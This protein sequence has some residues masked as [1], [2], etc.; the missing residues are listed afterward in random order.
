MLA[1][2]SRAA[3]KTTANDPKVKGLNPDTAG[4][5]SNGGKQK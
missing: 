2:S 3:G 4:T 1:S 5:R